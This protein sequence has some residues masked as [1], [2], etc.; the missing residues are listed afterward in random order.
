MLEVPCFRRFAE[1]FNAG[2]PVLL[3]IFG[4]CLPLAVSAIVIADDSPVLV[5]E[6]N[7][8]NWDD[9]VPHGKEVDAI[10]GDF[11]LQNSLLRAVIAKPVPTRNANMTVRTIGGC[12]I[13]LTT[14]KH[15]S[16]QLSAFYPARRAFAFGDVTEVSVSGSV[17]VVNGV[18]TES[19][20]AKLSVVAIGTKEKPRLKVTYS[21]QADQPYLTVESEWTNTTDADLNIVLE[22]DLRADSGK[23]DMP[24]S[25]NGTVDLFSFQDIFWQ[26]AYGVYAPGFKIRSNSNTRD[27]VLVYEPVDGKP[28]VLKPGE[29]FAMTRRLFVAQDLAGVMADSLDVRGQGDKL[30]ETRLAVFAIGQPVNGARISLKCGEE[31][32]GTLVT[33]EDGSVVRRLPSGTCEATVIVAGQEF[34][35]QKLTLTGAGR[36]SLELPDYVP[37]IASITIM[38]AEGRTIPAKIEFKG[39]NKT[40]TPNWGPESAEYFV[41]N[42]AYTANGRVQTEMAAGEYDITVSHGPEY[43]VEFT[44]LKVQPGKTNELKI[45]LPRVI[46]TPGWVSADF[47]SHSSPSGDNTSSQR[48]RVLNLAAEQIEFAPCTE[49]N[50]ISSYDDH[51]RALGLKPFLATV[52]GMELTGSPLPLNH[53]NVFPLIHRP[54]TQDGGAPV[55]DVSPE[56]Q[57]ERIAAWDNNSVKLIQQ[58]HPDIGWLFY[59]RNGDQQPDEGYSRSFGIMNVTEIHPIDPLLNPTRY[60]IYGGKETGNQT[61]LNWLQLLNQGFRI[62]GVV[63]TDSHYNYHGSGGLSIWVKSSTDDPAA[64][65][66]DELRDNSRSGHIVMS[67]GPYL[68][69]SFRETGSSD[70][71]VIAGQDL[72]AKS[73]KV[74]ATIQ[75]Q[76]PN[77]FDIDT[78]IVLVN[79]RRSDKLTYSRDT[80]PT[81]FGSDKDAVKFA[82]DVEVELTEDSHLIVLS[83]HRTQLIG[84][85]MGPMWGAQH[86]AALNNPVFVDIDGNGFKANKD[87]LDIPLPVK[88]IAEDKR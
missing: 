66:S 57:M 8:A 41:K 80:H 49:H 67:N 6:L 53:Q 79:G 30:V 40:P 55:T 44:K 47:H 32:W 29:S 88:F 36:H 15:E 85:V 16:D 37:G 78:V 72:V 76:C 52:S 86:P 12:L 58:N 18:K 7:E 56:A 54:H 59:D 21:V 11:V 13:D 14:R 77:W 63:N 17:E 31:S 20:E 71:S 70:A 45:T 39:N 81:M 65:N 84:D 73:K 68:D 28:V 19:G 75:V 4:C 3:A 43:N 51:I 10:Y 62:Y 35:T 23:E 87:T 69:A 82:H 46:E 38:D 74:T 5:Q 1:L 64:I 25:P 34:A 9:L 27:S 26:Q 22:D 50:R 24:K 83:G 2:V 60:H 61:A 48:G 42:L 33:G